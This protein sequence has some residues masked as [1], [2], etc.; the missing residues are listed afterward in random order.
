MELLLNEESDKID[1]LEDINITLKDHQRAIIKKCIDIEEINIC[2][3]GIMSDKPGTGKTYA[4]L[5][6]I[7]NSKKKR[8]I[9][10]VPQNIIQQW[11]DSIHKFSNGKLK[12]KRLTE[13]SDILELY[14]ET[15]NIGLFDYDILITTSL[16]YNVISTTITSNFLNV[17]NVFFDEIDSISSFVV[18]E[19]NA[20][21]VWFVSASIDY[22][23]LGIYTKK[24][25][26]DLIPY[27][28]CK[29]DDS[30]I[31][32]IFNLFEKNIYK[33][34]C[35]NLYLDNI[36]SG[37]LSS[38]EFRVLN[39]MDYSKLK[40]KF[41]NKIAQNEKEA[42]DYLVKDKLDTIE[43]EKLRIEDINAMITTYQEGDNRI[44]LLKKQLEKSTKSLEDSEYKLNLIKERLK[45]N[46][47]CPLC[48]NEFD[49]TQKKVLS[50]C[51]KNTICYECANNW[52][53]VMKKTNCIYCNIENMSFENY[54]ILKPLDENTCVLCEQEYENDDSKYYSNCCK[55]TA[56]TNCLKEWY[57]KLLNKECLYCHN[58]EI[59][60]EDFKNEK[61]HEET[62]LNLLD[63]VKY[64]RKTKIEFIEYFIK[65]KIYSNA[66]I[67][68]CSNYIRIFNDI[69]KLFLHY[70]VKFIELDDG[71]IYDIN[72]SVNE[73]KN[74]NINV[75]LLN[76]N[77]FGCGL[78]LEC[79]TD[80]LFLHKTEPTLEKQI[81]GRAQ[82]PG[83]RV[84]L[85]IW[86]IMHD[87]ETI[88]TTKKDNSDIFYNESLLLNKLNL[89]F[90]LN[91]DDNNDEYEDCTPINII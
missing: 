37:I 84:R 46:E 47:C 23:M 22:N 49:E 16:Y 83:R 45:D 65:T 72:R 12:Y 4:I 32:R 19:I 43:I 91:N 54:I 31:D 66:K 18:S 69:K 87:N 67:I 1:H 27:I 86:Y 36:F 28:T 5:G 75:L 8:N 38:E 50:Q 24:I 25:D 64:T 85:N 74:G 41:C 15:T 81:I 2:G 6:H 29:C 56:C 11:C 58:G 34:I 35:K 21:F 60:F 73:Y 48:Y 26:R 14:N 40:K 68:F 63:G 59:L 17:E 62:R 3:L 57:R 71:N 20:N 77:L 7:Y 79:T 39:A 9:I 44:N 61:E 88:I 10:V 76:S 13:Y 53:N 82:R 89:N 90:N 70:G 30:F 55:K 78:N 52:F 33:I 80:I 42:L 51:C